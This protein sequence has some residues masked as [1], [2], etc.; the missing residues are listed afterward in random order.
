MQQVGLFNSHLCTSLECKLL[1]QPA[2]RTG[3]WKSFVPAKLIKIL[4]LAGESIKTPECNPNIFT[5]GLNIVSVSNLKKSFSLLAVWFEQHSSS[6]ISLS[7]RRRLNI[8]SHFQCHWF[9]LINYWRDGV[10]AEPVLCRLSLLWD[11]C[12]HSGGL[13]FLNFLETP[14]LLL[15]GNPSTF[16]SFLKKH[17][18]DSK[19]QPLG[20][21]SL[22][23]GFKKRT[24]YKE[25]TWLRIKLSLY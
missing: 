22:L 12:S 21:K 24:S 13:Y 5:D 17:L 6:W 11:E 4:V 16:Q 14:A 18:G 19:Q 23:E 3:S 15:P 20:Y 7:Y 25:A 10:K 9:R 8:L 1:A 2:H